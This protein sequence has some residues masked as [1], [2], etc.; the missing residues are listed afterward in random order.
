MGT[1]A[2]EEKTPAGRTGNGESRGEC[3]RLEDLARKDAGVLTLADG[4]QWLLTKR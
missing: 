2:M 4:D 1:V 3:R